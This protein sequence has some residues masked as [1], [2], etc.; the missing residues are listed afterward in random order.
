MCQLVKDKDK[1][2]SGRLS[3]ALT[4]SI[5]RYLEVSR[6]EML[7]F[8]PG[9]LPGWAQTLSPMLKFR[10]AFRRLGTRIAR[11]PEDALSGRKSGILTRHVA[12]FG[13]R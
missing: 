1:N 10:R 3:R 9:P 5:H 2:M 13:T 4:D 12:L 7:L 8:W 6:S 11:N